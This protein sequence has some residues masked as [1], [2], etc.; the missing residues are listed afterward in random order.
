VRSIILA[1]ALTTA[2]PVVALA[3][4]DEDLRNA[5]KNQSEILA[6]G[7]SYSQQRFSPLN[8]INRQTVKRLVTTWSY[9]MT[10]N[11]GEESQALIKDGVMYVTSHDKTVA[12]DAL[13]GK[14]MWKTLIEY[15]PETTRVVCCGIVNRGAAIH[16]G[17]VVTKIT[18]LRA[19]QWTGYGS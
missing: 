14:E 16:Q 15:A 4:S 8:Q 5:G 11:H 10:S 9:S 1:M 2:L 6:Y 3:Q 12:V 7:M 17:I 13:A 19:D 18:H